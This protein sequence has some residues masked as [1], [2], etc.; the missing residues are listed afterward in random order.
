MLVAI[1]AVNPLALNIFMPS[2]PGMVRVFDTEYS[3][4]QLTLTL[5]LASIAVS[6]LFIGALSDRFGRRPIVIWGTALFLVATV[7]CI[8][9]PT[10]E[11]LIVGRIFQAFG[12]CTGMVMGRA[13][14][15]DMHGMDKAA[16]MMGYVTMAMVVVPMLA[17]LAGGHLDQQYGWQA[18]FI[19]V[20]LFGAIV[21]VFAWFG[22]GETHKG[23]YRAE[24][25]LRMFMNYGVLLG[26]IRFLRPALQISFSTGAFFAFLGGAPYITVELLG[27]TPVQ[28][29]IYFMIASVCYM[30]GNF[31][32]G[33]MSEKWGADRLVSIGLCFALVG[34]LWL[35]G[36]YLFTEIT[37]FKLFAGMGLF[38]LGNGMTLPS[39]TAGAVSADT[40]RVGAAAGLSGAMQLGAGSATS[41]L[42]G[43][44][45]TGATTALP[46]IAIMVSCAVLAFVVQIGGKWLEAKI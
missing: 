16:S 31:V 9:A 37:I 25:P 41:F 29:G 30:I 43:W 22:V 15:R 21:W 39:G 27:G 44:F 35:V 46:L 8:F 7:A 18:S 4:V 36:N 38:A 33:K 28:Y 24:N 26:N 3:T 20:L 2:M 23:P 19:L 34:G 5:F 42:A 45:L 1:S 12:G 40:S 10:I 32:T 6:Q 17:P 14:V 11:V 13:I